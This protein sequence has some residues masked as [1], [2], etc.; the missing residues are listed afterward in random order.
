[1]ADFLIWLLWSAALATVVV[2]LAFRRV[3]LPV[4]TLVL[5]FALAVY[6]L[7]GPGW[8]A[9]KVALW[10]LFAGLVALNSITFRREQLTLPLKPTG[11]EVMN[12]LDKT[13][14]DAAP[15]LAEI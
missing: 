10:V 14:H 1:M 8:L 15:R 9:W 6:A 11:L 7:F 13:L 12:T 2:T 5:G 3:D 4:S